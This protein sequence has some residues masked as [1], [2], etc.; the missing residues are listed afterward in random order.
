MELSGNGSG[1]QWPAWPSA[2]EIL[3]KPERTGKHGALSSRSLVQ[4]QIQPMAAGQR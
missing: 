2:R 1:V 3:L 4:T